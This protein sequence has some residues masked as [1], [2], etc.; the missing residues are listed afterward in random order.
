M[1]SNFGS[2]VLK[3]KVRKFSTSL[4]SFA[5]AHRK[6]MDLNNESDIK[7]LYMD[8][9]ATTP[10]DPRVLDAML[11][12]MISQYGNPHSRTHSYG[13]EAEKAVETARQHVG[14][15]IGADP[16]EIIFTSGATESNNI[17]IKGVAK[18]NKRKKNH[19]ITS[20]TEHKCVL[21]SCRYL[22][23]EGFNVTYLPVKSNGLVD[24]QVLKDAIRP[25]TSLLSIMFVN[26]EI[27]VQQPI[28]EIGAICKEKNIFFHTDAAQAVGKIPIDVNKLNVDLLSI[29][30]HKIYGPKGVGALYVRRRPRVRL[31]P[32]MSGGGQERGLRSG[33]LPAPLVVGLG[34]ACDIA[35]QEM[36]FDKK[37]IEKLSL[38]LIN[39]IMSQIDHVVRNG[40]PVKSYPGCIN[41]SFS[42]IEGESLLMAL[43]DIALSSGSAC[44]SASLEPSYVLRA[45]G[46]DDDMA[47]SSIRFGIGRFTTEREIDFT[48]QKC[49][50]NVNKLRE[51]SPLWEMIQEG[52]DLKSIKWSQH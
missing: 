44:T 30:G 38:R 16:K 3:C 18:F 2:W 21:D 14:N 35:R 12:Y 10:L 29:S 11:P 9:Q 36:E 32:M 43:K 47:H 13:W 51:M 50:N 5:A 1:I 49:V 33:T 23:G 46:A 4:K 20:Q 27:G 17:A 26:N 15:L 19:I 25:E 7:P 24:I 34:A 48:I 8:A 52:I 22:E 42:C 37:H 31:E 40:D 41:L 39:G 6:K 28:E 45:L